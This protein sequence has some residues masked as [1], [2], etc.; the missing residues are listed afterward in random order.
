[1]KT[2]TKKSKISD[3]EK[4]NEKW[5]SVQ[6]Q[7]RQTIAKKHLN[8]NSNNSNVKKKN[9]Q[10]KKRVDN[11]NTS[12]VF[13]VKHAST[14]LEMVNALKIMPKNHN[15]HFTYFN[16]RFSHKISARLNVRLSKDFPFFIS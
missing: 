6:N 5:C 14:L 12:V 13:A 10:C 2:N 8:N 3:V 16:R 1:M 7:Q 4:I 9:V 11:L 15:T